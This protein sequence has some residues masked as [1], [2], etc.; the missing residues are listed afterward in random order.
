MTKNIQA[1]SKGERILFGVC[2]VLFSLR[3]Y[4]YISVRVVFYQFV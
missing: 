4:S 2:F 1:R 3:A